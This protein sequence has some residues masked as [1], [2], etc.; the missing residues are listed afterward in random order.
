MVPLT[1]ASQVMDVP[2]ASPDQV[3]EPSAATVPDQEGHGS[4]LGMS[5]PSCATVSVLPTVVGW[6]EWAV[7]T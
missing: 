7:I 5:Q 2:P 4:R 1:V 6:H 3:M